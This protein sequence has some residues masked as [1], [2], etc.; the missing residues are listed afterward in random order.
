[1]I[2]G[3]GGSEPS[4]V[5]EA[6]AHSGITALSVAYFARPGLPSQ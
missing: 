5:G 6:L 1:M 2:G 4:C 3:S